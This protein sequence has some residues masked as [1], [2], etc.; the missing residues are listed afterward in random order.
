MLLESVEPFPVPTLGDQSLGLRTQA[1]EEGATETVYVTY[2]W[3]RRDRIIGDVAI[4]RAD[5][6]DVSQQAQTIA[7]LLDERIQQVLSQPATAT[8]APATSP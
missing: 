8:P 7:T 1:S 2:F 6:T 4:V 3:F 5:D